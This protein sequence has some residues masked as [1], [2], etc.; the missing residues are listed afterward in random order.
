MTTD[1][2]ASAVWI[3]CL[4]F[5]ALG[6]SACRAEEVGDAGLDAGDGGVGD[7]DLGDWNVTVDYRIACVPNEPCRRLLE[8]SSD[9]SISVTDPEG[10]I[11]LSAF[12]DPSVIARWG[13]FAAGLAE[14][15][16][17]WDPPTDLQEML[18]VTATR[19]SGAVTLD[20]AFGCVVGE[21]LG[22]STE[23]GVLLHDSVEAFQ[24]DLECPEWVTG[25]TEFEGTYLVDETPRFI[26]KPRF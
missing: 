2:R 26:C 13:S 14:G 21:P 22:S 1:S 15:D 24:D 19:A 3:R 25:P 23:L 5:I 6:C 4:L 7:V 20:S 9:G 10:E 18:V 12:V 8:V 11:D 16:C 17:A